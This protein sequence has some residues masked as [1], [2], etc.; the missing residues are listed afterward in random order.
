[1]RV[2]S[3]DAVVAESTVPASSCAGPSPDVAAP[4]WLVGREREGSTLP[5]HLSK[6]ASC[7][8]RLGVAR[9]SPHRALSR[10][11]ARPEVEVARRQTLKT[12]TAEQQQQ[13]QRQ[14]PVPPSCTAWLSHCK[15]RHVGK[16]PPKCPSHRAHEVGACHQYDIHASVCLMHSPSD[17][18]TTAT[19]SSID[20]GV[21]TRRSLHQASSKGAN[22]P[23]SR[24]PLDFRVGESRLAFESRTPS[25]CAQRVRGKRRCLSLSRARAVRPSHSDAASCLRS[26]VRLRV[27]L[28][29]GLW[30]SDMHA[31]CG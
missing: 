20:R 4:R 29:V 22:A 6:N 19:T 11:S 3:S 24:D 9:R 1:M 21:G 13:Q 18:Q 14:Q 10:S 8:P 7:I 28:R 31:F 5:A 12:H 15:H 2:Y 17:A 30:T 16:P 23:I 26:S 25:L 27:Q